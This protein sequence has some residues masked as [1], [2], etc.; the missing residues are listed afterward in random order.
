[1]GGAVKAITSPARIISSAASAIP[2]VGKIAGPVAGYI[3]GGPMGALSSIAGTALT[4]GYSGGGGGAP[5]GSAQVGQPLKPG[6]PLHPVSRC[7]ACLSCRLPAVVPQGGGRRRLAAD[8]GLVQVPRRRLSGV[9]RVVPGKAAV[10][11]RHPPE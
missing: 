6:Q 3:T 2:G 8:A 5:A 11:D 1:M 7:A 10:I 9:R 4:G